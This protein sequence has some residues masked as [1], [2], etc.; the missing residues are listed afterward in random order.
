MF[1][2]CKKPKEEPISPEKELETVSKRDQFI[3]N[4]S[5]EIKNPL[6]CLINA[7]EL[8]SNTQLTA[9]QSDLINVL[10]QSSKHL[11]YIIRDLSDYT[12]IKNNNLKII[13]EKVNINDIISEAMIILSQ[14]A[15]EK[16]IK[17]NY[18]VYKPMIVIESDGQRIRQI[19]LNVIFNSLKY[20]KEGSI[21]LKVT[22]TIKIPEVPDN[23]QEYLLFEITDT[24]IG[25]PEDKRHLLFKSF[26]NFND[27]FN[28]ETDGTGLGLYITGNII[29]QM[30][31][32]IDIQSKENIGTTV[33][34]WLPY[35]DCFSYH[36]NENIKMLLKKPVLILTKDNTLREI[37]C[38]QL[39]SWKM[40]IYLSQN[41]EHFIEMI[42]SGN[43]FKIYIIDDT[44]DILGI[45]TKINNRL[46]DVPTIIISNKDNIKY[47][48]S[49]IIPRTYNKELLFEAIFKMI[50]EVS[51]NNSPKS[52]NIAT[53]S[54]IPIPSIYKKYSI[55]IVEDSLNNK[56]VI[57]QILTMLNYTNINAVSSGYDAVDF[58]KDNDVDCILMD[59]K[60]PGMD[61]IECYN[62]IKKLSKKNKKQL[63]IIIA[64][65]A[66]I[67][68]EDRHLYQKIGF[69]ECISKPYT[70]E[71]IRNVMD[72]LLK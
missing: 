19:L 20:T 40:S 69:V 9:Q 57:K 68:D 2:K 56:I 48:N 17:I 34:I 27:S 42:D 24:G 4:I 41:E 11:Y 60:M 31:G 23:Q 65:S 45:Q 52:T 21:N 3:A 15:N 62:Q 10:T 16:K 30:E 25:I 39:Q 26:V 59:I 29:Q 72:K 18:H 43:T 58:F 22:K 64:V 36:T 7:T 35:K 46:F 12:S 54:S 1:K 49:I 6:N 53:L 33:K 14:K 5:H 28:R 51:P 67:N 55:L 38:T 47:K 66:T 8:L 63:P 32:F 71:H 13:S 37:I 50:F 61:G 70:I 44:V